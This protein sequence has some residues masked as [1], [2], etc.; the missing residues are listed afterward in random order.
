M[1]TETEA[2]AQAIAEMRL[3][4]G[5]SG[6]VVTY[7]RDIAEAAIT[8]LNRHRFERPGKVDDHARGYDDKIT[9][10]LE[11]TIDDSFDL[12]WTSRDAAKLIVSRMQ[13]EGLVLI[14]REGMRERVADAIDYEL[15]WKVEYAVWASGSSINDVLVAALTREEKLDLADTAIAAILGEG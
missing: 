9:D 2:V 12:G 1:T 6:T 14:A 15:I 8:A 5:G 4:W 3:D 13:S 10:W 7:D 11:T